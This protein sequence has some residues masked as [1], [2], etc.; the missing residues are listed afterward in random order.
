MQT[1]YIFATRSHHAQGR[2]H[3]QPQGMPYFLR[4]LNAVGAMGRGHTGNWGVLWGVNG[5]SCRLG[6]FGAH[7]LY[8]DR[9]RCAGGRFR[10]HEW[11]RSPPLP[12]RNCARQAPHSRWLSVWEVGRPRACAQKHPSQPPS[13]DSERHTRTVCLYSRLM[14]RYCREH[15]TTP[16]AIPITIHMQH[17]QPTART[18]QQA[19]SWKS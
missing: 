19:R 3:P 1:T 16:F 6:V 4:N 2:V 11:S 15:F 17:D 14:Q 18:T 7:C 8:R 12:Q 10:R 9:G 13:R 5:Q